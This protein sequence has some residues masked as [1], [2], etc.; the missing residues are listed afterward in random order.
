MHR[1]DWRYAWVVAAGI[2]ALVLPAFA[3]THPASGTQPQKRGM[4]ANG[5]MGMMQRT[6]GAPN[7]QWRHHRRQSA[8]P[9]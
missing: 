3:Q 1:H 6:G 9:G 4:M 5:C 2:S 7:S 8:G